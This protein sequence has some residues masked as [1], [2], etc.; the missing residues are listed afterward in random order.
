M[1]KSASAPSAQ[2]KIFNN[3]HGKISQL[4]QKLKTL[5]KEMEPKKKAKRK[6]KIN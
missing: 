5:S 4:T 2:N 6:I 1:P 3:Q